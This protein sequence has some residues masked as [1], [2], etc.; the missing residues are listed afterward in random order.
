MPFEIEAKYRLSLGAETLRSALNDHG[1]VPLPGFVIIDTYLRH[2]SRDFAKTGEAFRIRR[3]GDRNHLTYKAPKF[4]TVGVRSRP[5]IEVELAGDDATYDQT[6]AMFTAMG[7]EPVATL[8]KH[9]QPNKIEWQNQ[10]LKVEIDDAGELG[11]F[12]EVE[13]LLEDQADV[14]AAEAAIKS[15]AAALGLTD[16]EPR[17][18]L[19]MW[20]ERRGMI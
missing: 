20:L 11:L 12:A 14:P 5:E 15:L 4:K 10:R 7:F 19:R 13:V 3:E 17:S 9:R 8:R 1:A 16:Y 2:P 18:Y 6:L